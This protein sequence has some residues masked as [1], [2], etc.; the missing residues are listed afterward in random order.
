MP[1]RKNI[2]IKG[3]GIKVEK[4]GIEYC[5][6]VIVGNNIYLSDCVR[7]NLSTNSRITISGIIAEDTYGALFRSKYTIWVR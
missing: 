7:K 4:D 1:E 6:E 3:F 5:N 2:N